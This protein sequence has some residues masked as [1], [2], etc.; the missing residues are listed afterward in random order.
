MLTAVGGA[1]GIRTREMTLPDGK[2]VLLRSR[3]GF[4]EFITLGEDE[5]VAEGLPRGLVAYSFSALKDSEYAWSKPCML[6]YNAQSGEWKIVYYDPPQTKHAISP[7]TEKTKLYVWYWT[8]SVGRSCVYCDGVLFFGRAISSSMKNKKYRGKNKLYSR[9]KLIKAKVN[10]GSDTPV[11]PFVSRAEVDDKVITHLVVYQDGDYSRLSDVNGSIIF[12]HYGLKTYDDGE[13][14]YSTQ[15]PASISPDGSMVAMQSLVDRRFGVPGPQAYDRVKEKYYLNTL[16]QLPKF[17][18]STDARTLR[19]YSYFDGQHASNIG[20]D[21]NIGNVGECRGVALVNLGYRYIGGYVLHCS[22]T[23]PFQL[24]HYMSPRRKA[25]VIEYS[26]SVVIGKHHGYRN[27]TYSMTVDDSAQIGN[28]CGEVVYPITV[29]TSCGIDRQIHADGAKGQGTSAFDP[30][31]PDKVYCGEST[32]TEKKILVTN[33]ANDFITITASVGPIS[34]VVFEHVAAGGGSGTVNVINSW[35]ALLT[36]DQ[37]D[38]YYHGYPRVEF[39]AYNGGSMDYDGVVGSD[40]TDTPPCY[41][42]YVLFEGVKYY[43]TSCVA[44]VRSRPSLFE[45][46]QIAK[47][48]EPVYGPDGMVATANSRNLENSNTKSNYSGS[49]NFYAT[50]RT[51]LAADAQL[52]FVAYIEATVGA[53]LNYSVSE[54]D[55]PPVSPILNADHTVRFNFVVRYRGHEYSIPLI[56]K[57]VTKIGPW[58]R[59]EFE[60]WSKWPWEGLVEIPGQTFVQPP[61]MLPDAT[62]MNNIDNIFRH[63]GVCLDLAGV[64]NGEPNSGDGL[65]YSKRFNL[66]AINA[67]WI[68]TEYLVDECK[69]GAN[70]NSSDEELSKYYYCPDLKPLIEEKFFQVEFDNTGI[71][72]W[73]DVIPSRVDEVSPA[74]PPDRD[75]VCYRI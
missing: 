56:E 59:P 64:P 6:E 54:W 38:F 32:R 45:Q 29:R 4:P 61:L 24:S 52:E 71:R 27:D 37:Y 21:E 34:V 68:L 62:K 74:S 70:A 47:Y 72:A 63:Q 14:P 50:S 73:A 18:V 8:D 75:S 58:N 35:S 40:N 46:L 49:A 48:C 33:S 1:S 16:I 3:N 9:W 43:D 30:F 44:A 15:L 26:D 11:L 17:L 51:I 7:L 53:E 60:D 55:I 13:W 20:N 23:E 41:G 28:Y 22:M 10:F 67:N 65:I 25:D 39:M 66:A 36:G 69:R 19:T 42:N 5:Q 57:L 12:N 2:T 31:S